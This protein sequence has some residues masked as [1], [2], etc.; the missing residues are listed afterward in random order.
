MAKVEGKHYYSKS[1]AL[2]I[3]LRVGKKELV[4]GEMKTGEGKY[5]QFT[6]IGDGF[7]RFYSTDPEVIE[8]MDQR[9]AEV[10]DVF[11]PVEYQRRSIPAEKR[12]EMLERELSQANELIAKLQAE[13]K[14]RK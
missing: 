5:A 10:G 7:G 14:L 1:Q 12:S 11:G 2:Y 8:L 6:P 9:V 13:G 4:D 3:C